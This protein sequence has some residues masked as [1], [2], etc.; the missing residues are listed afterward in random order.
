MTNTDERATTVQ[1]DELMRLLL[2]STGHSIP[3][4]RCKRFV[5]EEVRS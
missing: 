3:G 1:F 2:I 5:K 4:Y